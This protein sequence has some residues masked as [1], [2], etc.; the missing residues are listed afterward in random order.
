MYKSLESMASSYTSRIGAGVL[1]LSTLLPV[2]GTVACSRDAE[3]TGA[4][5]TGISQRK[6]QPYTGRVQGNVDGIVDNVN[7]NQYLINFTISNV[8]SGAQELGLKSGDNIMIELTKS[9]IPS[10]YAE[11]V[12]SCKQPGAFKL[13]TNECGMDLDVTGLEGQGTQGQ[14]ASNRFNSVEV[15]TPFQQGVRGAKEK[16]SEL[17][18][19]AQEKAPGVT[20]GAKGGLDSLKKKIEGL[21]NKDEP[22]K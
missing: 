4:G 6:P 7:R 1:A 20:E 10:N 12:Q 15:I 2:L 9:A 16:A 5:Q 8:V 22:K 17:Y 14:Y 18:G 13:G 3:N 11:G 19:K 21:G